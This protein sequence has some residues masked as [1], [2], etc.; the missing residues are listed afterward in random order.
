MAIFAV[1]KDGVVENTIVADSLE[2]AELVTQNFCVELEEGNPAGINWTYNPTTKE[3][4]A[5]PKPEPVL[6][7]AE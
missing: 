3:F 2:I 7:P 6:P 4:T 1:I 5:P